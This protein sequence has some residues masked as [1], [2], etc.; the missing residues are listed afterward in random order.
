MLKAATIES[1]Q[2]VAQ[3]YWDL[4]VQKKY[5]VDI[6]KG[7]EVGHR[8]A[9]LVD[10]K[11]C[12]VLTAQFLTKHEHHARGTKRARSMGD[13]WLQDEGIY[14]PINVKTGLVGSEGQ[15]NLVSLKK[16]LTAV[17]ARWIDSYY[18]LLVKIQ[19]GTKI[20]PTVYLIDMLDY[21]NYVTFDSGPGQMM[22]KAKHFFA[23]Y[24]TAE[25]PKA[26]TLS[27][28]VKGLMA[29]L[30]DGEIRLRKN[31]DTKLQHFRTS[32]AAYLAGGI[33]PVTPETQQGLDLR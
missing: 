9:D 31:R 25:P 15:P 26:R 17:I 11:S 27:E 16:V 2:A 8:I 1:I 12:A 29:L 18:L 14:H 23:N 13:V 7:K 30:E 33:Q 21:L 22:L 10:E 3:A 24:S 5:F 4:E 19:V 20:V 32:V 6:A 28:K